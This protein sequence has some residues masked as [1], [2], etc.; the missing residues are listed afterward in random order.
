M[1]A[2]LPLEKNLAYLSVLNQKNEPLYT[3]NNKD[4]KLSL[5]FQL[6]LFSSL[7][8][9]DIFRITGEATGGYLSS[10]NIGDD[11]YYS[12]GHVFGSRIKVVVIME[13]IQLSERDKEEI[14]RVTSKI[15]EL[16]INDRLNPLS[17][18]LLPY[19]ESFVEQIQ[20]FLN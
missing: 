16:Y 3:L 9:F 7:D 15:H 2:A 12:Y 14:K 11:I 1:A 5:D 20:R 13:N 4:D 19:S 8:Q 18:G 10:T 6:M 17:T